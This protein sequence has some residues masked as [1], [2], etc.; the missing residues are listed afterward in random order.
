MIRFSDDKPASP[1]KPAAKPAAPKSADEPRTTIDLNGRP[2]SVPGEWSDADLAPF[3]K[4]L[5]AAKLNEKTV[6]K[7]KV[8]R[9]LMST[10]GDPAA[11]TAELTTLAAAVR[12]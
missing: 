8:G 12:A 2:L 7:T 9:H 3:L 10:L 5:G 6:G 4:A 1:A 11:V